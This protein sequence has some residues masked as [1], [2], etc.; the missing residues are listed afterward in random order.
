MIAET[1][2][3]AR[4]ILRHTSDDERFLSFPPGKSLRI[5]SKSAG[6]NMDLWSGE[7]DGRRGYFPYRYVKE[8]KVYV[9][10]PSHILP[11]VRRIIIHLLF[12]IQY[13]TYCHNLSTDQCYT[14]DV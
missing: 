4:T 5:L 14:Y 13:K 7:L 10:D 11:T 3:H 2:S 1:I 6:T 9:K 8:F 12:Y